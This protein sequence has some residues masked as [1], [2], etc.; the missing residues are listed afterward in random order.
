MNIFEDKNVFRENL[1]KAML[2]KGCRQIDLSRKTGIPV[3]TISRYM[4]GDI[5]PKIDYTNRIALA[6]NVN[7]MWL[8]GC[9]E[10]KVHEETYSFCPWCGKKL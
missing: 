1:K 4:S 3:S 7:P 5:L 10:A 2:S 8:F 6:L 9:E